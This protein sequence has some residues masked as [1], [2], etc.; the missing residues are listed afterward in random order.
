MCGCECVIVC[1]CV[2]VRVSKCKCAVN[3]DILSFWKGAKPHFNSLCQ[4]SPSVI[5]VEFTQLLLADF[6][7]EDDLGE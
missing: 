6:L 4:P 5:K 7:S 2:S 3:T 1:V